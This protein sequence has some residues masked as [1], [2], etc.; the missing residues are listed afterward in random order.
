[1]LWSAEGPLVGALAFVIPG[2]ALR[3]WNGLVPAVLPASTEHGERTFGAPQE[4]GRPRRLLGSSRPEIPG[5]QLQAHGRR[6]R[7]P[8]ERNADAT[9]IPAVRRQRSAAGR[10]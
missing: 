8:R 9:G 3:H 6:I 7:R 10:A 4:P 1:M 2:A 5:H